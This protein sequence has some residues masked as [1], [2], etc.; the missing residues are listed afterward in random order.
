ML[1]FFLNAFV[2]VPAILFSTFNCGKFE[3][4]NEIPSKIRRNKKKK[5][6]S[7][8]NDEGRLKELPND[9]IKSTTSTTS[10][11]KSCV[12]NWKAKRKDSVKNRDR[13]KKPEQNHF[14]TNDP[15]Y[16]ILNK[17]NIVFEDKKKNNIP[18][19]YSMSPPEGFMAQKTIMAAPVI[20]VPEHKLA[21]TDD[22]NYQTLANLA[23]CFDEK[24]PANSKP[25]MAIQT[26][27]GVVTPAAL[28]HGTNL[29][30]ATIKLLPTWT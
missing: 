2:L 3:I 12:D 1:V 27:M 8:G 6:L 28:D 10:H 18:P 9:K 23:P 14:V 22:R 5:H 24:K 11:R 17:I 4:P 15:N 26:I 20:K 30:P 19:A 21:P 29:A 13:F 7:L 25:P 16:Q